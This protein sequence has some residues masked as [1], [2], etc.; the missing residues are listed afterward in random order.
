M[1]NKKGKFIDLEELDRDS[2][3]EYCRDL[4]ARIEALF[5]PV[6][7]NTNPLLKKRVQR[8]MM[9][10]FNNKDIKRRNRHTL[11]VENLTAE[12]SR[13]ME[14][15][16]A[17]RFELLEEFL[18]DHV[19]SRKQLGEVEHCNNAYEVKQAIGP[20][21]ADTLSNYELYYIQEG[22]KRSGIS[23]TILYQ[24]FQEW[25]ILNRT[26]PRVTELT[27]L[28]GPGFILAELEARMIREYKSTTFDEIV[29]GT[30]PALLKDPAAYE[31]ATRKQNQQNESRQAVHPELTEADKLG[32]EEI[33]RGKLH[34]LFNGTTGSLG[35]GPSKE[36][37]DAQML[38]YLKEFIGSQTWFG[39][40]V[41]NLTG[42]VRSSGRCLY[43]P[44]L[45]FNNI[46][47]FGG[48]RPEAVG[49]GGESPIVVVASIQRNSHS[50]MSKESRSRK[51][52]FVQLYL[53]KKGR[54]LLF[55]PTFF[56]YY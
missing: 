46:H 10:D 52:I 31:Q 48:N 11:W 23:V 5:T 25:M 9:E 37:G 29:E 33:V 40:Q 14:D 44:E 18:H 6:V 2:L 53:T 41:E 3:E 22:W 28:I 8:F 4:Q 12:S 30:N 50:R 35:F 42:T 54:E 16:D 19:I 32:L 47:G 24:M 21:K 1:A 17:L 36:P 45:E 26:D 51:S 39:R 55:N 38:Q 20:I 49:G 27:T 43:I 13:R 34:A 56:P 7:A 15:K